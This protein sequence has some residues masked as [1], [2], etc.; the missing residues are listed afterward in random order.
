MVKSYM[1]LSFAVCVTVLCLRSNKDNFS[2]KSLSDGTRTEF[3]EFVVSPGIGYAV[4]TM[5]S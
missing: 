5:K 1:I 2:K 4:L 3:K